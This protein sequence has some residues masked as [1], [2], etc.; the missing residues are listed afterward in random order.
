MKDLDFLGDHNRFGGKALFKPIKPDN[1]YKAV[2]T[3]LVES[4]FVMHSQ[5]TP[6]ARLR[7]FLKKSST[8]K[9]MR[10]RV[11]HLIG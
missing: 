8:A 3:S 7:I 6:V 2:F 5:G 1:Q 9:S 10:C 11:K 4:G